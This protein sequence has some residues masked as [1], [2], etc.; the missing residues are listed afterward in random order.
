MEV[1]LSNQHFLLKIQGFFEKLRIVLMTLSAI[2]GPLPVNLE[3][4]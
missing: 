3:E 1:H 4:C 2:D